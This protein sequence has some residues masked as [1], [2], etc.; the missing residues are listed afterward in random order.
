MKPLWY[1]TGESFMYSS[2]K[3][4][5]SGVNFENYREWNWK[6]G[7]N[8]AGGYVHHGANHMEDNYG[9]LKVEMVQARIRL[10]VTALGMVGSPTPCQPTLEITLSKDHSSNSLFACW[11]PHRGVAVVSKMPC[12][13]LCVCLRS[14]RSKHGTIVNVR[15]SRSYRDLCSRC[16][17]YQLF[18]VR[19]QR[20]FNTLIVASVIYRVFP[21][22]WY[23]IFWLY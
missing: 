9:H 20:S 5:K 2:G 7:L 23:N 17:R 13:S 10:D 14:W 19:L 3:S 18:L 4:R 16:L 11:L 8:G 12:A 22:S 6:V 1:W 21:K 15:V